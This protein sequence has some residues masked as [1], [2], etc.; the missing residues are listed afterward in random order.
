LEQKGNVRQATGGIPQGTLVLRDTSGTAQQAVLGSFSFSTEG[1]G[2]TPGNPLSLI[3]ASETPAEA[4]MLSQW[5]DAQWAS[6]KEQP[7]AKALLV[8][9]IKALA[10]HRDPVSVYAVMLHHLFTAVGDGMDEDRIV[11][12]ATGIRN[13]VVW[14]KLY[15]SSATALSARSTSWNASAAASL[16]IASASAKPSR[17][18]R[19]SSITSC[20]TTAF[21]CCAPSAC[22]TTGRSTRATTAATFWRRIA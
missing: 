19:S 15:N 4:Q 22:A 14:K 1:L 16:P 3:Q 12:S 13:T 21:S 8:E 2:L 10:A 17:R 6:L 20:A 5:F 7:E 18:W 9:R 11:K